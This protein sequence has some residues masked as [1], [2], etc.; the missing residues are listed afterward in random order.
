MR[1]SEENWENSGQTSKRMSCNADRGSLFAP[2]R[3]FSHS[4]RQMG[5][6]YDVYVRISVQITGDEKCC[7]EEEVLDSG[8]AA[9]IFVL[10]EEAAVDLE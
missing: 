2:E 5:G 1:I 3:V 4:A 7:L 10:E 9:L 6:S 8:D